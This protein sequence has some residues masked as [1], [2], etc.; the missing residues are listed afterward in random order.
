MMNLKNVTIVFLITSLFFIASCSGASNSVENVPQAFI[1]G[2]NGVQ[3]EFEPFS[4]QE[5]GIFTIFDSEDFPIEVAVTN[6]GEQSLEPG[7]VTLTLLGPSQDSFSH[8]PAWELSTAASIEKISEFNPDGGEEIVSFTPGDF[9]MYTDPVVGFVDVAWN[10]NYRYDYATHLIIND[11]CFKGDLRDERV[12]EVAEPKQ[13]SVSSA[14]IIVDRVEEDNAGQGIVLLKIS[15]RNAQTGE[16]T[17]VGEEYD[18]RFS[19]VSY[20]IDE[21]DTWTCKSG[22]RENEARLIDGTAQIICR[23]SDPLSEEDLYSQ[24]VALTFNYEYQDLIV[25]TLRIK[26]SAE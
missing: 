15:I 11:V 2:I 16:S 22:G 21:P 4:I 25:K 6:K 14:P 12:C 19:Q 18:D 13:F 17:F 20:T 24:P 9:A 1:G 26:Q 5:E 23:L 3:V 10:L 7:E 8:I